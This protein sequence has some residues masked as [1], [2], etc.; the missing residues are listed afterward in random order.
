MNRTIVFAL[1]TVLP[2]LA[3]ACASVAGKRVFD[4][5]D[6]ADDVPYS[7][8]VQVEDTLY[9]AGTLGL[10]PAT[11]AVPA[12]VADEVRFAMDGIA[13]KLALAGMDMSDVVSVQ[14]FC[15]DVSLYAAFNEVYRTYFDGEYPAR[16]FVGSGPLLRGAHFEICATAAR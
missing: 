4:P 16:A 9:V 3:S 7:H 12:A 6:R 10:D 1:L 14:V 8:A 2:L 15:S 13:A 11:G 5:A